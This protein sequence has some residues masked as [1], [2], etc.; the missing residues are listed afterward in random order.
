MKILSE[1]NWQAHLPEALSPLIRRLILTSGSLTL[2]LNDVCGQ[3][4]K[5]EVLFQGMLELQH[6]GDSWGI[7]HHDNT[8]ARS[9]WV[10]E[11]LLFCGDQPVLYAVSRVAFACLD[12]REAFEQGRHPFSALQ[13]LGDQPLGYWLAQQEDMTRSE[14]EYARFRYQT[15]DIGEEKARFALKDRLPSRRSFLCRAG[16]SLELIE[17]FLTSES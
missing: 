8:E 9:V 14:F 4:V 5:V 17:V 2:A 12:E 11:V 16:Q 13:T 6:R 1:I 7:P 10:R 3:A 15:E